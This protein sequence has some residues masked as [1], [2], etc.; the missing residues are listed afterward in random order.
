[1]QLWPIFLVLK[2]NM[3]NYSLEKSMKRLG[4]GTDIIMEELKDEL[5]AAFHM[6][7]TNQHSR[8]YSIIW[9]IRDRFYN[10]G[11]RADMVLSILEEKMNKEKEKS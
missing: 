4:D 6:L 10:L 2:F 11:N 7:E 1:M 5:E 8:A 3:Q 9:A